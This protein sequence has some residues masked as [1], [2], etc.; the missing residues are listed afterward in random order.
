MQSTPT[1]WIMNAAD[2][3]IKWFGMGHA[4]YELLVQPKTKDRSSW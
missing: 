3:M 1:D 4:Y 2:A